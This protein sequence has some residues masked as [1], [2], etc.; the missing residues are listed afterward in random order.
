MKSRRENNT[1]RRKHASPSVSVIIPVY[2]AEKYLRQMLETVEAQTLKNIEIICVNDGSTDRS[3]E[4][5]EQFRKRD[6][7]ITCLMQQNLNA[8]AARNNGLRVAKG[9]Y[10]V[11]WDADDKFDKRTLEMMYEKAKRTKADIC[12]CGVYEFTDEGKSYEADGYLRREFL[13]GKDPFNKYDISERFFDFA[14]NVLWN[15]MFR[16]KYLVEK[17]LSFQNIRQANDTAFVMLSLFLAESVT[18]LEKKLVYYRINN[19]DSLTGKSSETVFCPFEAY[20]H[21][22][23]EIKKYPDFS[24]VQKSFRNKTAKGMFRA[25]NIQTSFE[26]YV[27]L[28]EFLQREGLKRL[29]LDKC[30]KEDMEEDWIYH[31]LEKIKTMAAGDFLLYKSNERRWDRDQLKYTLR[32]VRRKLALLLWLN[33]KLKEMKKLVK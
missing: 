33:E 31:D 27:K 22:L 30:R 26:E 13:P 9:E 8:G 1:M 12:V 29:E 21:T 15:K 10:V 17:G 23:Q 4:I 7:R 25:L 3:G 32:R 5:L 14:S 11:F 16:R 19:P 24:K 18:C 2:N 28:Y 6:S 20:E